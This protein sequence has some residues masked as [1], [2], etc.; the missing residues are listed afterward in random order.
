MIQRCVTPAKWQSTV[1]DVRC[2]EYE[3][4]HSFAFFISHMSGNC[5]ARSV[6]HPWCCYEVSFFSSVVGP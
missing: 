3:K 4:F 1:S 6:V 2:M 5:D